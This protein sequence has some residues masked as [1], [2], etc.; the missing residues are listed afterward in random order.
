MVLSA[1]QTGLEIL[2][3]YTSS[4]PLVSKGTN[5][6]CELACLH[7]KRI[8]QNLCLTCHVAH[9]LNFVENEKNHI[10]QAKEI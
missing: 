10:S 8:R 9:Q 5:I 2:I 3:K 1:S 4:G 6:V 7:L